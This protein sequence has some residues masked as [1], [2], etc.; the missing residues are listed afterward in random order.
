MLGKEAVIAYEYMLNNVDIFGRD[1]LW[2]FYNDE[3]KYL[4]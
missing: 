3:R 2:L 1:I 4:S